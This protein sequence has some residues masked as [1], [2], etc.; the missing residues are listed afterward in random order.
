MKVLEWLTFEVLSKFYSA[1]IDD[2]TILLDELQVGDIEYRRGFAR[3]SK[4]WKL[5]ERSYMPKSA[6][7]L[8]ST[9]IP[10]L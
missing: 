6:N 2:I 7:D 10:T 4:H 9:I 8:H 1:K 3:W 5:K